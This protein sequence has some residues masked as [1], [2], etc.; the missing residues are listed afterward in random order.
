MPHETNSRPRRRVLDTRQVSQQFTLGSQLKTRCAN[1]IAQPGCG[2][3]VDVCF[4]S[5]PL[6]KCS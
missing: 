2:A 4:G 1:E 5:I 6:K 3:R